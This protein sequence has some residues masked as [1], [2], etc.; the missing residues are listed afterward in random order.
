MHSTRE[1]GGHGSAVWSS[2]QPSAGAQGAFQKGAS[3][4]RLCM[5]TPSLHRLSKRYHCGCSEIK[6]LL[7]TPL[8]QAHRAHARGTVAWIH[9]SLYYK[10]KDC[11]M[12]L[13]SKCS[14]S[15]LTSWQSKLLNWLL[16]HT[17]YFLSNGFL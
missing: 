16:I 17:L 2:L 4:S 7:P 9:F 13:N 15:S 11:L 8:H 6:F 10:L 5:Q 1:G 3:L 14:F 12:K